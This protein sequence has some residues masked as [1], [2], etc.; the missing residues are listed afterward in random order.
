MTN[1]MSTDQ[2][3]PERLKQLE[4]L[5]WFLSNNAPLEYSKLVFEAVEFI[6]EMVTAL[7]RIRKLE[8]SPLKENEYELIKRF[9]EWK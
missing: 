4:S 6:S 9:K 5:A 1:Q 8:Y 7:E 3:M 2:E